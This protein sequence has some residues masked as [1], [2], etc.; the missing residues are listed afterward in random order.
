M[1]AIFGIIDFEGRPL[2]EEWIRSMQKDL[3]HRGPDGQ[4]LYREPSVAL[5]H[6]LLQVTPESIYDKS[7]YEED[8]YV[9]TA[10]ARLDEREAIMDRIGTPPSER[11]KITDPLLLL[12]SF[13]KFGKDFVKDIYGD[14]AFAIWDKNK[15]ELFCARDQIGVKSF[16]Y[17]R[18]E[19]KFIFSSELRAIARLK[20]IDTNID[21]LYL[22][23]QVLYLYNKSSETNWK[24]IKRLDAANLLILINSKIKLRKYWDLRYHRSST[25]TVEESASGLRE[26]IYKAVSDRMRTEGETGVPLSGGLDSGSIACIASGI[27]RG[28]GKNLTTVST[29]LGPDNRNIDETD[30]SDYIN[31]I[32]RRETNIEALFIPHTELN[33]LDSVFEKFDR[34]Y[35]LYGSYNY[36]DEAIFS[37]FS[38]KGVKRILHGYLGDQ[39]TSNSSI[40][41]L[42]HLF[43]SGRFRSFLKLTHIYKEKTGLNIKEVLK[44]EFLLPLTPHFLLNLWSKLKG[45]GRSQ[46]LLDFESIPLKLQEKEKREIR[47]LKNKFGK[48]YY[49]YKIAVTENIWPDRNGYFREDWDCGSSHHQIEI[50]YPLADR[51]ILE[52]LMSVPV[53]HFEADGIKRGLLRK[54]MNGILPDLVKD[55]KGKGF[56]S[57]GYIHIIK[58]DLPKLFKLIEQGSKTNLE[59]PQNFDIIK[60]KKEIKDLINLKNLSSFTTINW[61]M[62]E[63]GLWLLFN[64]WNKDK[65]SKTLTDENKK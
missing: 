25:M 37:E 34:Y 11:D 53:E 4:G 33:F 3:S 23:N 6:M 7:P 9:I 24:D 58:K 48:K 40:R 59:I 63:S 49:K 55:R 51:R 30:E 62:V 41:P 43:F 1:S 65:H 52:F 57:P 28:K 60:I 39:T 27:L 42:V 16:L 29:I 56:Y 47:R 8:G 22:R 12:R 13:K 35:A 21:N 45:I 38:L 19:D 32:I 50:T 2:K 54:S 44:K 18:N 5:G 15:K 10:N 64:I 61:Q 20:F 17:Y 36:V 26:I 31:A 46:Y 14:F